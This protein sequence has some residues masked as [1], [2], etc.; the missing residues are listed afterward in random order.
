MMHV[1]DVC[2]LVD[3]DSTEKDC[4]YCNRC[5]AWLCVADKKSGIRRSL[6]AL[7]R[8]KS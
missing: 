8:L 2:R 1:C 6:A 5:K 3:G 4:T 7:K